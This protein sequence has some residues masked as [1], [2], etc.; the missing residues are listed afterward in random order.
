MHAQVPQE[1][2]FCYLVYLKAFP[3]RRAMRSKHSRYM[4]KSKLSDCRFQVTLEPAR[5]GTYKSEPLK[6]PLA[7]AAPWN[8]D[9]TLTITPEIYFTVSWMMRAGP[10]ACMQVVVIPA[11]TVPSRQR[12]ERREWCELHNGVG[13]AHG[14]PS[15]CRR[16]ARRYARR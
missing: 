2:F 7:V 9:G 1:V 15:R 12:R 14:R 3:D 10:L 11:P 13:R 6:S 4:G 8:P 5:R 16:S